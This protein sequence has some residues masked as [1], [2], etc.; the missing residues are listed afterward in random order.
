[1]P[2]AVQRFTLEA[3]TNGFI[4]IVQTSVFAGMIS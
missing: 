2:P 3:Q 4:L 1:M